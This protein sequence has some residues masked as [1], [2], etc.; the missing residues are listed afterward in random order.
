MNYTIIKNVENKYKDRQFKFK[1]YFYLFQEKKH[2][3]V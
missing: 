1:K 2:T 3:Q